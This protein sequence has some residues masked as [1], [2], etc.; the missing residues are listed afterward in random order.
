MGTIIVS[1]ERI[2]RAHDVIQ[3]ILPG[4]SSFSLAP[5]RP[6]LR[7]RAGVLGRGF[8][9]NSGF[10]EARSQRLGCYWSRVKS[11]M[12]TS[13]SFFYEPDLRRRTFISPTHKRTEGRA[14]V[15][16]SEFTSKRR[17]TTGGIQQKPLLG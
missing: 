15:G 5:F 17:R 1:P 7:L 10:V 4:A 6:R 16:G 9:H 2:S 11:H 8:D 3:L 14:P 13:S 12:E